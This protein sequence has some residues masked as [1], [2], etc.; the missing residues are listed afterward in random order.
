MLNIKLKKALSAERFLDLLGQC[1]FSL[2]QIVSLSKSEEFKP[3]DKVQQD[4]P[5][6]IQ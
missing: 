3:L 6:M 5:F 4:W 1:V 2:Q